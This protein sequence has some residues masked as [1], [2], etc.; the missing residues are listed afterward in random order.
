MAVFSVLF[1]LIAKGYKM[2]DYMESGD[3]VANPADEL[4]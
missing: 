4:T 1:A 3:V 2:T